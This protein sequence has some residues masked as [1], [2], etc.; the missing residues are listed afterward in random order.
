MDEVKQNVHFVLGHPNGWVGQPQQRLRESAKLGGL[1]LSS[2]EVQEKVK[3]VTEGEASTLTCLASSFAPNL[4]KPGYRFIVLDAGGGTLDISSYVVVESK[5][6]RLNE[7]ALP[8]CRFAGSIFVNKK[9]REFLSGVLRG[10]EF[11]DDATIEELV[12]TQ[13]EKNQKPAFCDPD[14][15]YRLRMNTKKSVNKL[16]IRNGHLPVSGQK[17]AEWFDFSVAQAVDS[18]IAAGKKIRKDGERLS[19]WIVGGFGSSPWLFKRMKEVLGDKDFSLCQPDSNLAKAVADG[20]VRHYLFGS[21]T[22]RISRASY[23]TVCGTTFN[24]FDPDHIKRLDLLRPS[25]TGG[26]IIGPVFSCIANKNESI[27]ESRTYTSMYSHIFLDAEDAKHTSSSIY[28]YD[29]DG[30]VPVW[31][32]ENRGK[33]RELFT[34]EADLSDGCIDK[35]RHSLGG[36]FDFWAV[37]FEIELK[38]GTTEVEARIKW[39]QDGKTKYGPVRIIYE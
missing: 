4:L 37:E 24:P 8:D 28:C 31:F 5:P 7:I 2:E 36:I 6:L 29:G 39:E 26:H 15:Q 9:A 11:G 20:A 12:S 21:V 10:S 38:L 34:L 17:I 13:F 14:R 25:P 1:V 18:V 30:P 22:A 16:N 23:G 33:F 3:F 35:E 27:A 32:N 19:V